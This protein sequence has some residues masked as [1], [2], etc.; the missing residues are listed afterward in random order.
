MRVLGT[1]ILEE[2]QHDHADVRSWISAWLAEVKDAEWTTPQDIK[3]RYQSASFLSD[4][5]VIFN[6][7][8]TKYRMVC[9]ISFQFNIVRVQW[10]GT[11][12]EYSKRY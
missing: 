6:V 8:G 5:L 10:A 4:R 12:A 1:T 11:H 9:K 3:N 2:F 7:K